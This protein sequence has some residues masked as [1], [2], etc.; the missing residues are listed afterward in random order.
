VAKPIDLTTGRQS[1]SEA[2]MS[3]VDSTGL[4]RI[5]WYAGHGIAQ[6]HWDAPAL[7]LKAPPDLGFPFV[8]LDYESGICAQVRQTPAN[9]TREMT[10]F[11]ITACQE[12]LRRLP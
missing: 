1:E 5:Y 3:I 8:E 11:E 10:A 12:Y 2:H 7:E 9:A 6:F 4:K